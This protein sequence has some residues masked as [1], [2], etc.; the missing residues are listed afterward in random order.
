MSETEGLLAWEVLGKDV[1]RSTARYLLTYPRK[2]WMNKGAKSVALVLRYL[3]GE[4]DEP[5]ANDNALYLPDLEDAEPI[6]TWAKVRKHYDKRYRREW[7]T[8]ECRYCG[9]VL[10]PEAG[11]DASWELDH[12]PAIKA[13][14]AGLVQARVVVDSCRKCNRA[15]G[16]SSLDCLVERSQVLSEADADRGISARLVLCT[17]SA[18]QR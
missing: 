15:L 4:F 3:A 12:V 6:P 2:T 7:L 1:K 5:G 8:G 9:V 18:C 14:N 10:Y 16:D 11:R 17:C 13:V